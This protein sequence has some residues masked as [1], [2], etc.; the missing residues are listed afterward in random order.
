[1]K[2]IISLG[3]FLLFHNQL[4]Q[5]G[6]NV[7][8]LY[9]NVIPRHFLQYQLNKPEQ[10][11]DEQALEDE[12]KDYPENEPTFPRGMNFWLPYHLTE[13]LNWKDKRS[14]FMRRSQDIPMFSGGNW[15]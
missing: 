5:E 6:C 10:V 4:N 12:I 13:P 2:I 7:N 8:G 3:I 1:M 14:S 11:K 15:G 9:I